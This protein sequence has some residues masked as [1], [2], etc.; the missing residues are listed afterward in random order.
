[1]TEG[2][3]RPAVAEAL[4]GASSVAVCGHVHPD[5]D[6]IGS[7]LGATLA[8]R[9]AGVA[10]SPLVAE[11]HPP[12]VYSFLPCYEGLVRAA[13]APPADVFLALDT[14]GAERLGDGAA[15]AAEA[16]AVV[17]LD[18]HPDNTGFGDVRWVAPGS[19][20]VGEMLWRLLPD[21]G[22]GPDRDVATCLYTALMTDTGRFQHSNTTA[23]AL[24]VAAEMVDAGADPTA[25]A[26]A[27]Y[28]SRSTGALALQGLVLSRITTTNDGA[29][30]YSWFEDA[31]LEATGATIEET[32]DLVDAV[33]ATDGPQ[34]AFLAKAG[35]DATRVSLR[36]KGSFDVG[37]VARS[38]G[39]GGHRAA[40]GLTVEG[41]LDEVLASVLPLLPGAER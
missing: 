37:A 2:A 31:D 16:R 36:A 13:D 14:T 41:G 32:E 25:I 17:V 33:R 9:A 7:T 30:A 21:L 15:I 1:M 11:G 3:D 18:H 24:R 23:D 22:V 34:V 35:A 26:S 40:A 28:Q 10:A 38:L 20:A 8:L 27:V 4:L 19:A 5:G 6:A 12:P 39:G 29:V